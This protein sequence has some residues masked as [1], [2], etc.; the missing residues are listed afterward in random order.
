MLATH[1]GF[2]NTS[3]TRTHVRFPFSTHAAAGGNVA[4][5]SA[6]EAA[7]IAI[8]KATDGAAFSATKRSSSNGVTMTSPFNSLTGVHTVDID[9][10]DNTDAGFYASG[11][12]YA[13]M[14]SPDTETIDS[15]TITGVVLAYFEIGVGKADVTHWNGTAVTSPNTAGTPV[16]DVGRINNVSTSSVTTVNANIGTTQPTNFTGTGASALVKG[17]MVDIAGAAVSTSLAQIG[18]NVVNIGGTAQTARDIGASVLLSSGTGTGQLDFTSGVVKANLTQISG[19]AVSTSTAQLGVNVVQAGGTAWGSGAI[20]AGAIA[21]DAITAAKI[22]DGAIDRATFAEDTG[23]RTGR[24]CTLQAGTTSSITLDSGASSNTGDYVGWYAKI[25]S[26][27]GFGQAPRLITFSN[28]V[29]KLC[30]IY[31]HYTTAPDNTTVVTLIP[32]GSAVDLY[33][34]G[35]VEPNPLVSQRVDVSVGAMQNNV[36]TAAAVASDAVSEIQSGLA[37]S[38]AL[39]TLSGI[40]TGITSL[41]QWLGALAGKQTANS[42]ARTEIRATGGGSGTFDETTDSLEALRDNVGTAGAGLTAADDA[43]ITAIAALSIPTAAQNATAVLTTQMTESYR[44]AGS[45]PTLAQAQFEL[46]AHM[47]DSSISGTTKTLNNIA[48][49]AAKTFT[50]NSATTPTSITETT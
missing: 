36:V 27:T 16:V 12:L 8:Y 47:G 18:V 4:P 41:A 7:D 11:C 3:S 1:L 35:G 14:L 32:A 33:T 21:S 49:T 45:A 9:L 24:S 15:Q 29:T 5:L 37:T 28:G 10:T 22:A 42:T 31:P 25:E 50:L 46:I 48:G 30:D 6:F 43:V 38:S 13:V 2:Y 34:W 39:S 40:F 44:S 17:D 23:L 20:T 19:S 26:G